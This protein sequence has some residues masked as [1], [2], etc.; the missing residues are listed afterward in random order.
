MISFDFFTMQGKVINLLNYSLFEVVAK[1]IINVSEFLI[2]R[3][4]KGLW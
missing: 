4:M 2:T 1:K 3:Y